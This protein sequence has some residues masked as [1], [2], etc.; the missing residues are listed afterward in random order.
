[1][2]T[3]QP[4]AT[5]TPLP[6]VDASEPFPWSRVIFAAGALGLLVAIGVLAKRRLAEGSDGPGSDGPDSDGEGSDGAASESGRS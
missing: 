1:M 2:G 3:P 4:G 6:A 5:A